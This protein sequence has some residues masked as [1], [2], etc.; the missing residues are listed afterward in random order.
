[1]DSIQEYHEVQLRQAFSNNTQW[2]IHNDHY[3][4]HCLMECYVVQSGRNSPKIA[5]CLL[6]LSSAIM[7]ERSRHSKTSVN[8]Y[9]I[10]KTELVLTFH[11]VCSS[12]SCLYGELIHSHLNVRMELHIYRLPY[13]PL[14]LLLDILVSL[15]PLLITVAGALMSQ[16]WHSQMWGGAHWSVQCTPSHTLKLIF[17]VQIALRGTIEVDADFSSWNGYRGHSWIVPC[18]C[19]GRPLT[20]DLLKLFLT[21]CWNRLFS[22]PTFRTIPENGC[23]LSQFHFPPLTKGNIMVLKRALTISF[24]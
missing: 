16:C 18:W 17:Q 1:M 13:E 11:Q 23:I 15:K 6:G 4:S 5:A 7:L 3:M 19:D 12:A 14:S 22:T 21:C 24:P 20:W 10:T 9:Q 2:E 8:F